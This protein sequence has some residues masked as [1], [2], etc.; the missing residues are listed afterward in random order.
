MGLRAA[1]VGSPDVVM[2]PAL[3]ET[4]QSQNFKFGSSSVSLSLKGRISEKDLIEKDLPHEGM[5][6]HSPP[7][8]TYSINGLVKNLKNEFLSINHSNEEMSNEG[9]QEDDDFKGLVI[10]ND[11]L[12]TPE[13]ELGQE[14]V[15]ELLSTLKPVGFEFEKDFLDVINMSEDVMG[16][17]SVP[18]P[19]KDK[20]TIISER[21]ENSK[22]CLHQFHR[23]RAFLL[24]RLR[25]LEGTFLGK[26]VSEEITGLI[27]YCTGMLESANRGVNRVEPG[28]KSS[29]AAM[30]L[31]MRQV[32]HAATSQASAVARS[33]SRNF[34][35]FGSGSST[36]ATPDRNGI[37][38]S[39]SGILPPLG[40]EVQR[41]LEVVSRELS[42]QQ[43]KVLQDL[44]SDATES[45]S[46]GESADEMIA[47]NNP[48]Q[49]PLS[50]NKRC[51]WRWAEDRASIASRW[52]W[53]QS[54]IADLD[55]KIRQVND[56]RR[57][58]KTNKGPVKL[59]NQPP[60]ECVEETC[61][62]VRPLNRAS[63][64]KRKVVTLSGSLR[65][66][67][68]A[69]RPSS[70]RCSCRGVTLLAG[71]MT[72]HSCGLCAGRLLDP[73]GPRDPLEMNP[74]NE[75]VALL[76]PGFH[77]QLSFPSDVSQSL[78]YNAIM[79][80]PEWQ[81]RASRIQNRASTSTSADV[82]PDQT[83]RGRKPTS[84]GLAG[85]GSVVLPSLPPHPTPVTGPSTSTTLQD[86]HIDAERSRA[87]VVAVSS[88]V[89][90]KNGR[91]GGRRGRRNH[92]GG[93]DRVHKRRKYSN[94]YVDGREYD[95]VDL[96]EDDSLLP[97]SPVPSPASVA[98]KDKEMIQLKR[99]RENSYDID[100]IVIPYSMAAATRTEM[101]KYKEILTPK[102]R[103]LK[104]EHSAV[105]TVEHKNGVVRRP[106]HD[107]EGHED[108]SDEAYVSRHDRCE[109]DEKKKFLSYMKR[110]A[111][112]GSGAQAGPGGRG[113]GRARTD[114]RAESSG[115][116]TPDPMSP[117][118]TATVDSLT[119]PPATPAP[120]DDTP[121]PSSSA[122]VSSASRRRTV[123]SSKV[124]A[125]EIPQAQTYVEYIPE[126]SHYEPRQFPLSDEEYKKMLM[127]SSEGTSNCNFS[128]SISKTPFYELESLY[129][130]RSVSTDSADSLT[131]EDPNDPEW[132]SAEGP[133]R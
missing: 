26:H 27:E 10:N 71:G 111:G 99:K 69:N 81:A 43:R 120:P 58:I 90:R 121:A 93:N 56:I 12:A 128:D 33:A 42:A 107:V 47:Y 51:L 132:T 17:V 16:L 4:Q 98:S 21:I 129:S 23:R 100:N 94:L 110:N 2:A 3:T 125:P 52:I 103:R 101:L 108:L 34:K 123:S 7:T 8:K 92:V 57:Q 73:T 28:K 117:D 44:D 89:R 127:E 25:K 84:I 11:D 36:T 54:Q 20:E 119:S 82:S 45:S 68:R 15:E 76:D 113:R 130:P 83:S 91:G 29:F 35:Y 124:S 67:K 53:L 116:N 96:L 115:P 62:R 106:S 14:E 19:S 22:K 13:N 80:T 41:E 1:S 74:V 49:H 59:E 133:R 24:Q 114:S 126:G 87:A 63:F 97:V 64:T 70:V 37:R 60:S 102:W 105:N 131:V 38:S 122:S 5:N 109:I 65:G 40:L 78:H 31:F 88:K 118:P 9:H 79:R 55:Y 50:I 46:G 112:A 75:R 39:S 77:P 72:E 85:G 95:A 18:V 32:D 66:N 30:S 6:G 61:A 86:Y 48:Q 104:E